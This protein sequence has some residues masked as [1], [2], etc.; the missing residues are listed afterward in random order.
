MSSAP[1]E[2]FAALIGLIGVPGFIA[3]LVFGGIAGACDKKG[4]KK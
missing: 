2:A 4:N 1:F 3:L